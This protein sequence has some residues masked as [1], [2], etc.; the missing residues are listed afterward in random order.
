MTTRAFFK[1]PPSLKR[2]PAA[3]YH[4]LY[5]LSRGARRRATISNIYLLSRKELTV[6]V[7]HAQFM[8]NVVVL[9]S[10]FTRHT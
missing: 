10:F 4:P 3:A 1:D 8:Q 6:G 7:D 5:R 9:N 2:P